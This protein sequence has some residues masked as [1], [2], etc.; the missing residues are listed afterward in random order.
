MPELTPGASAILRHDHVAFQFSGGKDSTAALFLLRDFWPSMTVYWL[1]SGDSFPE[2][3]EFIRSVAASLPRFVEV[4]GRVNETIA[5]FGPPSD[6]IP[7]GASEAAW[8]MGVGSG[9]QLQDR[10]LCCARSKMVPLHQHM[11]DDGIT[12]IVR[13]QKSADDYR[14]PFQSGQCADGFE[15][16]Y[17]IEQW[18]D[19]DVMALLSGQ[20]LLPPLY[21]AG[22]TRSGDC[23]RCSAWLG[24]RRANYLAEHHPL[25]F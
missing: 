18:S 6:L 17:P 2:T 1:N 21:G 13:G 25:V 22:L 10:S 7:Y 4:A 5:A 19:S 15:F 16:Y 14:G 3:A 24:D 12:L 20:G 8:A 9:P 23:M 11:I